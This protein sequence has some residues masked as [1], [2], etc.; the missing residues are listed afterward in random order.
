MEHN[1]VRRS[2]LGALLFL[3]IVV[4][5]A[6]LAW[7]LVSDETGTPDRKPLRHRGSERTVRAATDSAPASRPSDDGPVEA[8]VA[9]P[10]PG[11]IRGRVIDRGEIPVNHAVVRFVLK[12]PPGQRNF[13]LVARFDETTKV[14]EEGRFSFMVPGGG[15]YQVVAD[16]EGFAPAVKNGVKPGDEIELQLDVGASLS[17]IVVD[18]V[19]GKG[20]EAATVEVSAEKGATVRKA[21]TSASGEFAVKDLPAGKLAV[22]VEHPLYIPRNALEQ[23]VQAG[24]ASSMRIEMDPGKSIKGQVMAADDGRQIEGATVTVRKKKACTDATGRF[25]IRGLEAE[26]HELQVAA[27]G[28]QADQRPINLAGSRSEAVAEILLNRGA[29]IRGRIQNEKSEP[30]AGAELKLFETWDDWSY[31]DWMTRHLNVKSGED[32]TFKLTGIPARE[33]LTLSLRVRCKG[34]PETFEKGIKIVRNDDEIYLPIALRQ[35]AVISGRVMDQENRPVSGARL[36]LRVQNTGGWWVGGEDPNLTVSGSGSDG[37]FKF[38][39]LG[40]GN[41]VLSAHVRGFSSAFKN[42]LDLT[43]GGSRTDVILSVESGSPLKGIVVDP[44]EK[45]IA[46]ANVNVWTQKGNGQAVSDAEGKFV[47]EAVPKGPYDVYATAVGFGA[48]RLMK[49][50]PAGDVGLRIVM[51]REAVLRGTVVDAQTK[52]PVTKFRAFLFA[53]D[54]RQGGWRQ[55]RWGGI[56]GDPEGKFQIQAPQGSYRLEVMSTGYVKGKKEGIVL[57]AGTDPDPVKLELKAGGAIEGII[58]GENGQPEPW[59]QI[60]VG[61]DDGTLAF[62]GHA[63]SEHDG[64]FFVGDLDSGNYS[65][66]IQRHEAPILVQ[67]GVYVGGERPAFVDAQIQTVAAVTF[68]F[69]IER[70]KDKEDEVT[71]GVTL[72]EGSSP[73]PPPPP[74]QPTAPAKPWRAPRVRAWIESLDGAPLA[75][76]QEW[77]GPEPKFKPLTRKDLY[78]PHRTERFSMPVRD[79]P[80]GRYVLRATARGYVDTRIPFQIQQGAR[81]RLPVEMKLLPKEL[82]PD[83]PEGPRLRIGHWF[84]GEGNRHEYRYYEDE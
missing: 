8:L 29:T 19:T 69:L 17:A 14:D 56:E 74:P 30:V 53:E 12:V 42:D 28:Y 16:A 64:Y 33:W 77:N 15:T 13:A 63:S 76:S 9:A 65:V 83:V 18:K 81:W 71:A 32:G 24:E 72:P 57:Q 1:P 51:K 80:A 49:Q 50:L 40:F 47:V 46:G 66:V 6:T 36:E 79:L 45:P 43:G 38:E 58:R 20:I 60:Y 5:A 22:T 39:G 44:D 67:G 2:R 34:Y 41:Y 27:E 23:V 25:V 37:E 21:V 10:V 26:S 78:V 73:P 70:P 54:T 31:E 68:D 82:R 7:R 48:T 35:G 61:K 75:V 3:A 62:S 55:P 4:G 84:D 52:K 59:V 11:A